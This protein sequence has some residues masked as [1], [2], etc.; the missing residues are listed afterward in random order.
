MVILK[1]S[2]S[3]CANGHIF[4]PSKK[5]CPECGEPVY[6]Y[7]GMTRSQWRAWSIDEAKREMEGEDDE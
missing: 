3:E 6:T 2:E 4:A 7:D 5:T 1:V